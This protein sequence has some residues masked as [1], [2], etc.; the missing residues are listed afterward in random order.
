MTG[1]LVFLRLPFQSESGWK[2]HPSCRSQANLAPG[3]EPGYMYE[4]IGQ[5]DVQRFDAMIFGLAWLGLGV[6]LG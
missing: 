2:L 3:H 4:V 5:V 6:G 1:G